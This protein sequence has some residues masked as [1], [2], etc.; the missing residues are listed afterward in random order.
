MQALWMLPVAI[1]FIM[2]GAYGRTLNLTVYR[3]TPRNYTG[4]VDFD[5][6]NNTLGALMNRIPGM[7]IR[8][9]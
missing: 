2:S 1:L 6:G 5:T 9:S 3:I 8:H 7:L 4:I